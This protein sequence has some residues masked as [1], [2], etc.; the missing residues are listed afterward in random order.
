MGLG[1]K[2]IFESKQ[3]FLSIIF[4]IIVIP[5]IILSISSSIL[6][7]DSEDFFKDFK[8]YYGWASDFLQGKD[9]YKNW[10]DYPPSFFIFIIP[11][12]FLKIDT[13][14]S[15]YFIINVI[16]LIVISQLFVRIL[17]YYNVNLTTIKKIFIFVSIVLF[18]PNRDILFTGQINI[19]IVFLTTLFYYLFFI[20]KR[21]IGASICLSLAIFIKIWPIALIPLLFKRKK[22]IVAFSGIFASFLILFLIIFGIQMHFEF[23]RTFL[24][25]ETKVASVVIPTEFE[26]LRYS[27]DY[28][29]SITHTLFKVLSFLGITSHTLELLNTF[30]IIPKLVILAAIIYIILNI[31]DKSKEGEI[32]AFSLSL[33]W[34]FIL[35]NFAGSSY[36]AFFSLPFALTLLVLE[37]KN[38][39]KIMFASIFLLIPSLFAIPYLSLKIGGIAPMLV[40][41]TPPYFYVFIIWLMILFIKIKKVK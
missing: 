2:R 18:Y 29:W 17:E 40:Y 34:I 35:A 26:S 20:R 13:A 16:L 28:N 14:I 8:I 36:F 33:T 11:F 39:E 32:L 4:L 25:L 10:V 22:A 30:L 21:Y 1:F 41:L 15:I 37:S 7:V 5:P 27:M 31:M 19:V 9:P 38:A 23:G 12:T 6:G 3:N 24:L